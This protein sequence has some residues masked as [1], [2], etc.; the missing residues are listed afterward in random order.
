MGRRVKVDIEEQTLRNDED[1]PVEGVVA[2]CVECGHQ[3]ESFGTGSAS[4]RRCLALLRD[5]CPQDENNFYI[6]KDE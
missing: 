6:D 4:R 5:E 3:T 2:T 1:V